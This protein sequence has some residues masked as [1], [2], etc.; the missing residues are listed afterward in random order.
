MLRHW[1]TQLAAVLVAVGL[2]GCATGGGGATDT[3]PIEPVDDYRIGAGD[4]LQIFVWQHPEVSVTVP[5]RPDGRISS[6][7]VEDMVA[8]GKTPSELA[9]DM[10]VALSEYIRSPNVSVI[11]TNFVGTFDTQVRV[12][13]EAARPAAVP[14]RQ[15]MTVLDVLIAVGGLSPSAAGNRAR[16]IR[17]ANGVEEEIS[18]RLKDLLNKG[19][20]AEN[21]VLRPGDVLIIPQSLL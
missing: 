3:V 1:L 5:V 21:V 8:V 10:Q 16:I 20:I 18:V 15:N 7:L 2:Q 6:P 9:E 11:V 19:A 12:V 14:Y 17:R 4:T 13:G